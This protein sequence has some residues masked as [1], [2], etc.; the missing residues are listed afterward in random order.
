M[1]GG[2]DD[3]GGGDDDGSGDDD[4]DDDDYCGV[5]GKDLP[6][7]IMFCDWLSET[8]LSKMIIVR[9]TRSLERRL[10]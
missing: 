3:A 7:M 2:G 6:K 1:I 8:N 9:V 5:E 4:G 10:L